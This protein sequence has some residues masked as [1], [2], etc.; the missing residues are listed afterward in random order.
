M[1]SENMQDGIGTIFDLS[2]C[3][4][5]LQV[6]LVTYFRRGHGELRGL[7]PPEGSKACCC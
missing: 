1:L 5:S 7:G 3:T 6:I 4:V 2:L